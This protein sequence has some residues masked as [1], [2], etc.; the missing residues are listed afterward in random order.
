MEKSKDYLR[1][2]VKIVL[3][4]RADVIATSG[5]GE[6]KEDDGGWTTISDWS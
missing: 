4:E 5:Y 6:N 2:E 3:F 1:A